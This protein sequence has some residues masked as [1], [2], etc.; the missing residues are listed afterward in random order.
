MEKFKTIT[1]VFNQNFETLYRW[2]HLRNIPHRLPDAVR[3]FIAQLLSDN[4]SASKLYV[5]QPEYRGAY[6]TLGFPDHSVL[7]PPS[8]LFEDDGTFE[9]VST[10]SITLSWLADLDGDIDKLDA[11]DPGH[12]FRRARSIIDSLTTLSRDETP[13]VQAAVA[14][15]ISA[16]HRKL[17]AT[18]LA[19]GKQ[20]RHARQWRALTDRALAQGLEFPLPVGTAIPA[21]VKKKVKVR[22]AVGGS[23]PTAPRSHHTGPAQQEET[24]TMS[25]K[26]K[27]LITFNRQLHVVPSEFR[28]LL[29]ALNA[30]IMPSQDLRA[31]CGSL[32]VLFSG[33]DAAHGLPF[34]VPEIRRFAR[35]LHAAWPHGPFFCDLATDYLGIE[36]F[37][38]LDHFLVIERSDS[39]E[40]QLFINTNELARHVG[41]CHRNI[42]ALGKQARMSKVEIAD[43]L[44]QVDQYIVQRFGPWQQE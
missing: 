10:N 6:G 26:A 25:L 23:G 9:L 12:C 31:K 15:L 36:V 11:K 24:Q 37:A 5:D 39:P 33:Y 30:P 35:K 13:L 28:F 42:K 20:P 21:G 38:H 14:E 44:E 19:G 17:E 27:I 2:R 1:D 29:A 4:E 40:F 18:F 3:F 16:L 43:R 32:Q 41:E 8:Y 34:L 22:K 7:W